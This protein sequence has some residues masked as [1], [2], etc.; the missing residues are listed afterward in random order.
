MYNVLVGLVAPEKPGVRSSR[1][2]VVDGETMTITNL[3]NLNEILGKL[4]A[5][6]KEIGYL[7]PEQTSVILRSWTS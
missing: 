1:W 2:F 6:G 5:D 7:T 3:I 4:K